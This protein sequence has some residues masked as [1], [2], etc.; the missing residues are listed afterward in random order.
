[1]E[2]KVMLVRESFTNI[3]ATSSETKGTIDVMEYTI[4]WDAK[5]GTIHMV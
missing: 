5:H 3:K 4:S 1:M 2:D